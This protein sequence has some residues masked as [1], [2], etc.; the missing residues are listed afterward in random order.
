[1]S[2]Q[3]T[4]HVIRGATMITM[5]LCSVLSNKVIFETF[6]E[7]FFDYFL[8]VEMTE[9]NF[10]AR[11]FGPEGNT[12]DQSFV[13]FKGKKPVGILLGGI[14]QL[15]D[16][17]TLRCGGMAVIPSARKKGIARKM[18]IR[19]EELGRAAGV[20]QLF[21]EILTINKSAYNFYES[22]GYEKVYD[23]T[24]RN[25]T[26]D[27]HWFQGGPE[28]IFAHQEAFYSIQEITLT[29]LEALRHHDESH[30]PWQGSL[31]YVATIDV[32]VFGV[33]KNGQLIAG[34]IGNQ[35]NLFYIYVLPGHRLT[36]V[37]KALLKAYI[38][39]CKVE[40]CRFVYTNNARLH[41]FS[42]HLKM[43]TSDYGQYEYYKW[44]EELK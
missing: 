40:N 31:D 16:I 38:Q 35:E 20:H 22:I 6:K 36:G 18:M 26:P 5:K 11:F 42:N 4:I 10:M 1:M 12:K 28:E 29:D 37:G 34:L 32:T 9:D 19:H 27:S 44:L 21:L 13:A 7:G 14:R 33:Y 39:T 2:K 8:K 43:T 25:F 15:G 23:L 30:L 17:K 24:Y 3:A 41:T